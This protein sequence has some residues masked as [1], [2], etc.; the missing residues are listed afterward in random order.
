MT[1]RAV[2]WIVAVLLVAGLPAPAFGQVKRRPPAADLQSA[3]EKLKST[4]AGRILE[5]L[6]EVKANPRAAPTAVALVEEILRRGATAD[7]AEAAIE[8]LG[9]AGAA[10]SSAVIRPYARH[11]LMD[12]RHAAILALAS[13]KGPEAALAFREGLRQSDAFVREA[14]AEGLGRI[15]ASDAV[16]D[17]FL[18]LDRGVSKAG[19]AIGGLCGPAECLKL[20]GQLGPQGGGALARGL[21]PVF[22]RASALPD[23]TLVA[24]AGQLRNLHTMEASAYLASVLSRWPKKGSQKV[25]N[26]LAGEDAAISK[27]QGAGGK[28]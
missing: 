22:F 5:G 20:A 23:E 28:P 7:V 10:S 25:R 21:D 12:L 2:T 9:A 13:T 24:I 14:S 18:A 15:G 27:P 16:G 3:E 19:P 6:A 11:R 8:T 26:A 4:D 1:I 17:L